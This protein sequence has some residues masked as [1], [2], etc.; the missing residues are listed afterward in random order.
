SYD[1]GSNALSIAPNWQATDSDER[2]IMYVAAE[3]ELP[4]L[5]GATVGV[6]LYLSDY[7][8]T[9]YPGMAIQIY[10]QQNG[11]S[12]SGNYG[13]NIALTSGEDLGNGWYRFE[14][15][16]ENVPVEPSAQ[17]VGIKLQGAGLT[18]REASADAILL[19]RITV[20]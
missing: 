5:E 10:I 13:G 11:G 8:I 1:S 9:T 15:V 20:E 14:R 6:E 16:M 4:D 19:R 18:A 17:R 12:Y 7:Y 3:G 2:T